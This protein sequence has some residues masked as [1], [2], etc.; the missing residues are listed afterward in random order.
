[1][2]AIF[3]DRVVVTLD[4]DMKLAEESTKETEP[5]VPATVKD[6]ADHIE[7]KQ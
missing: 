3:G 4:G 6:G 1:M 7:N 2:A 5:D